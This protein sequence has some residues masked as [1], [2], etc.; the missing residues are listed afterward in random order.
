MFKLLTVICAVE[1]IALR[2]G[3]DYLAFFNILNR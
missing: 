3:Y 2:S 1:F